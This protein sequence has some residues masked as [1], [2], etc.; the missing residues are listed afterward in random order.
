M[1]IASAL[2]VLALLVT[3]GCSPYR[4]PPPAPATVTA[5][6]PPPITGTVV[7]QPQP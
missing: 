7:V 3:S 1:R 4:D 2:G 5:V 6:Q